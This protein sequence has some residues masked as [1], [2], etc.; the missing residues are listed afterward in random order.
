MNKKTKP[1]GSLLDGFTFDD[2]EYLVDG[3]P[4]LRGYLRGYLAELRLEQMLKT[5]PGVT[6]VKKIPDPEDR[7]G[8]FEVIYFDEPVTIECKSVEVNTITEDTL[9][10]S[11]K[12]SVCIKTSCRPVVINGEQTR[13]SYIQKGTFD[14]L[15]V[16]TY[17]VDQNWGFLFMENKY[18]PESVPGFAST[19]L[20]V[21]P[22]ET[23]GV[24]DDI[25]ALLDKVIKAR[26]Q[27][28]IGYSGNTIE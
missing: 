25:K 2:I 19:K 17:A 8:D 11:W 1:M 14:I 22:Q 24:T 6:S 5:V 26:A 9:H 4:Y 27:A 28:K 21:N 23:A 3:N 7:K 20:W 10:D 18:L 13:S 12:G 15:A 16:S